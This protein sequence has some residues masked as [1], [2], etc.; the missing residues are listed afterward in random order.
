MKKKNIK[1]AQPIRNT[2]RIV[3]LVY[4]AICYLS[5]LVSPGYFWLFGFF[6]LSIPLILAGHAFLLILA[7]PGFGRPLFLHLT[8]LVFGFPFI[9]ATIS[10][11]P[12]TEGQ[13]KVLSYNVRVFNNYATLMNKNFESSKKMVGWSVENDAQIKCFQEYYNNDKSDVFNIKKKLTK[14]GWPYSHS[15][16]VLRDRSGAEFGLAIF[17]KYRIVKKG[18]M[19]GKNGEFLNSIYVDVVKGKDTLRIYCTHLESMSINE[20]NVLNTDKLAQ[21]YKDTGWRLRSGFV[22]RATQVRA[23]VKNI[24]D[25]KHRIVLCGDLNEVPYSFVYYL[26][27]RKL[28]NAFEEA[29]KGLGFTYNGRLFF[30][31]IDHQFFSDNIKIHN[32]TTHRNIK[33]SD[34]FPLT[35]TYSW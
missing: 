20:E 13:L 35:A 12:Q 17:S 18:E 3:F 7:I 31:R 23:L 19:K 4:T 33:Y 34:H 24:E 29:G 9:N 32:F 30:L 27:H 15:K 16:I 25:C 8:A 28:E 10:F 5:V 6:S 14:A 22:A 1:P 2:L 11:N 26:L 21:S